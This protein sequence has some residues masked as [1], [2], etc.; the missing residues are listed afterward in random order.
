[1]PPVNHQ[2]VDAGV[3]AFQA[4]SDQELFILGT[5][6]HLWLA[7]A[8]F[9]T[10]PPH[11]QEIDENVSAFQGISNTQVLVLRSDNNLWLEHCLTSLGH[12]LPALYFAY[13]TGGA[14]LEAVSTDFNAALKSP[15]AGSV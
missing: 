7:R 5:D 13:N 3:K 2:R 4:L 11:R 15:A 9:G 10:V 8:P 14:Q 6:G 1:V 12:Y